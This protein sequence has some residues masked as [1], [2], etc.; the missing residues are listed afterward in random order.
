LKSFVKYNFFIDYT[1][2]KVAKQSGRTLHNELIKTLTTLFKKKHESQQDL[3]FLIHL[4]RNF[5]FFLLLIIKSQYLFFGQTSKNNTNRIK[6]LV[7]KDYYGSLQSFFDISSQIIVTLCDN[8]KN[9]QPEDLLF[10]LKSFNNSLAF[11]IK[12]SY[13]DSLCKKS[14]R[15]NFFLIT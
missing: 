5:W 13:I 3:T 10:W 6:V 14:I 7:D 4:I 2:C 1:R 8:I 15:T 12:V 9:C 11:F